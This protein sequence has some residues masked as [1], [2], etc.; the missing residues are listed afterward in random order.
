MPSK[1][2]EFFTAAKTLTPKEAC[3]E[4]AYKVLNGSKTVS[5]VFN[6]QF[7]KISLI[8]NYNFFLKKQNIVFACIGKPNT[9]K[10][11]EFKK[12]L[13][14]NENKKAIDTYSNLLKVLNVKNK[15]FEQNLL[16]DF[17]ED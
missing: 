7:D 4:Y 6:S 16:N 12:S 13:Q 5:D 10:R 14:K 17:L 15:Q 3:A 11:S 1:I 8:D 9:E 2:K